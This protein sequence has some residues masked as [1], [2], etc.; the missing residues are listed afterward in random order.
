MSHDCSHHGWTVADDRQAMMVPSPNRN[1]IS[2]V[3][4][5]IRLSEV[6]QPPGYNRPICQQRNGVKIS[7]R[8][9]CYIG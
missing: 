1:N 2:E 9:G 7:R 3:C 6:I 5:D 8:D 4:W